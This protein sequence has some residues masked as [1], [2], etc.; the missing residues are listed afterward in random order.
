MFPGIFEN[1]G[2]YICASATESYLVNPELPQPSVYRCHFC[3]A[4]SEPY[5]STNALFKSPNSFSTTNPIDSSLDDN[6]SPI[7]FL[8]GSSLLIKNVITIGSSSKCHTSL[9]FCAPMLS[10]C[11]VIIWFARFGLY[12]N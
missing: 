4:G 5:T 2:A 6:I 10:N 8:A 3:S 9:I 7:A 11:S 12:L 1:H